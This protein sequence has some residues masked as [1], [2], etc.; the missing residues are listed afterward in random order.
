MDCSHRQLAIFRELPVG[1]IRVMETWDREQ[2]GISSGQMLPAVEVW[3]AL[4]FARV[5]VW[6]LGAVCTHYFV[7]QG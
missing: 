6:G 4:Q 1:S 5:G 2:L 3:E 7:V